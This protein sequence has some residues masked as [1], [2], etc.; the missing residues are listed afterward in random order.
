MS[1]TDIN[2]TGPQLE[3]RNSLNSDTDS[4]AVLS[5][6]GKTS[7]ETERKRPMFLFLKSRM[8]LVQSD[9]LE[10]CGQPWGEVTDMTECVLAFPRL[11]GETEQFR[12]VY[13]VI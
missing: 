3:L 7:G 13:K 11:Q 8:I 10:F 9:H 2:Y 6:E 4:L 12:T 1:T 5:P